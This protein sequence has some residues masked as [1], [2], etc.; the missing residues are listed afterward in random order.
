[1]PPIFDIKN[2][3]FSVFG[4]DMSHLE[5][6]ATLTGAYAVWLSYKENVWSWVVGLS[7]VSLAFILFYQIQLYPDMLLQVFF[8]ITNIIGFWSWKFPKE[9]E[10]NHKK[11]LKISMLPLKTSA[12][13]IGIGL[14]A[15][16]LLGT[17]SKNLHEL[18][19][20]IFSLPSAFPYTDS[21]TTVMSI[22]ATFMLI[23]KNVEAWWMWLVIDIISTY[24]YF[25]KDVKLYALLYLGFC[26]IAVVGAL[27]WTRKWKLER[28]VSA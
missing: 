2:I 18:F 14:V 16:F 8:F 6:W 24:M 5:F 19:P 27:E 12:I 15:T 11:E 9:V 26:I 13:L 20:A 21:F 17:F 7:S 10:A 28:T 25:V 1:M 22:V 23:R 4:Y 3:F